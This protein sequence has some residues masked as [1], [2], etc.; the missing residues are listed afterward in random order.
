[1]TQ[2]FDTRRPN[3]DLAQKTFYRVTGKAFN[4]MSPPLSKYQRGARD[5][6]NEFEWDSGLGGESVAGQVKG[7][8]LNQSRLDGLSQPDEGWAYLQWTMEFRNDH[9]E[10]QREARAEVQLPPGGVVSRVTLWVNGEPREAAFAGRGEVRAAYQKVAVQ[11]RRDPVLVTTTGPDRVLV[12]CFPISPGGGTMK[13]RLGITAP[14]LI[15]HTNQAV[16]RLPCLV[17]RNFKVRSAFEHSFWLETPKK[18]RADFAKSAG[19]G[20]TRFSTRWD[21]IFSCSMAGRISK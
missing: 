6:F 12:Q 13:I 16:L 17:E 7:L 1:M 20:K 15:E 2:M 10:S 19:G 3:S 11:Q 9:P 14:L 8:S 4:S 5:L 18:A 21:S